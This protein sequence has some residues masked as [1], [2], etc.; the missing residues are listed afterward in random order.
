MM[1]PPDLAPLRTP[2]GPQRGGPTP[3]TCPRAWTRAHRL[4]RS[5]I[6]LPLF[7]KIFQQFR[8]SGRIAAIPPISPSPL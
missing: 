6:G 1:V 4:A 2:P 5:P 3:P 8:R 7:S